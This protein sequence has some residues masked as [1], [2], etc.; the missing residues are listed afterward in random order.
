MKEKTIYKRKFDESRYNVSLEKEKYS[1]GI[2]RKVVF[3]HSATMIIHPDEWKK[4]FLPNMFTDSETQVF[5]DEQGFLWKIFF[6]SDS[7]TVKEVRGSLSAEIDYRRFW[8]E[9]Q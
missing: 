2:L 5:K 1:W 8:K 3:G 6:T 4:Y 9:L 7:V